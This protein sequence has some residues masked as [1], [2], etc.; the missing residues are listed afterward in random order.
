MSNPLPLDSTAFAV[1][2]SPD[3]K[4]R[5]VGNVDTPSGHVSPRRRHSAVK[6]LL[7]VGL[8]SVAALTG[9]L[10]TPPGAKASFPCSKHINVVLMF[11]AAAPTPTGLNGCWT[12]SIPPGALGAY[13]ICRGSDG[14]HFGTGRNYIFDD[15]NPSRPLLGNGGEND[16]LGSHCHVV[17]TFTNYAEMMAAGS[18]SWCTDPVRSLNQPCWRRNSAAGAI[19]YFAELYSDGNVYNLKDNWNCTRAYG[20]CPSNSR[21]VINVAHAGDPGYTTVSTA[22]TWEC[23][24]TAEGQYMAIYSGLAVS[25]TKMT[26]VVN[27]LNNCTI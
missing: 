18:G 7:V 26:A 12:Y 6:A 10:A 14:Q 19:R 1:R 25:S 24:Q 17:G 21:P 8:I 27:T 4:L 16:R 13:F 9:T 5:K 3:A 23:G 15:T 2:A 11:Y 20:A 22:V